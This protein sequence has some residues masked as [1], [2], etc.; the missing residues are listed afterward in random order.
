M[1]PWW[2][3]NIIQSSDG[4]ESPWKQQQVHEPAHDLGIKALLGIALPHVMASY[5]S[6]FLF[7]E[8]RGFSFSFPM[9]CLS[10]EQQQTPQMI[11]EA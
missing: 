9:A 4:A 10:L 7:E 2:N 6:F 1:N 5:W 11:R 3:I 8:E